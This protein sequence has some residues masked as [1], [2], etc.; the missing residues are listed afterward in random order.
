MEVGCD[1]NQEAAK[2]HKKS[3]RPFSDGGDKIGFL[4]FF[5][6]LFYDQ[7]AFYAA[8]KG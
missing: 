8:V 1:S 3:L 6:F 5:P 4:A 7:S 2:F